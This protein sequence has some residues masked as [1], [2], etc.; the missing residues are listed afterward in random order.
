MTEPLLV[1]LATE[2]ARAE[3]AFARLPERLGGAHLPRRP[4]WTC[5]ACQTLDTP[6]PCAPALVLLSE[7]HAGDDA[8]LA[9]LLGAL[10]AAAMADQPGSL[11]Q[12]MLHAWRLR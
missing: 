11:R 2:A 9:A 7:H 10:H 3:H 5:D 8:E 1:A 6:W 4:Q 12:E